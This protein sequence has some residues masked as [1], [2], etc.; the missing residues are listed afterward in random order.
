MHKHND[1][2]FWGKAAMSGAVGSPRSQTEL[3]AIAVNTAISQGAT[4]G[5]DPKTRKFKSLRGMRSQLVYQL[6]QQILVTY[7]SNSATA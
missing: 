3:Q 2:R 4:V 5:K 1:P 6:G 7:S